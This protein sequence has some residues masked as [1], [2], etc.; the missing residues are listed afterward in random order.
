MTRRPVVWSEAKV[1]YEALL[2]LMIQST[3]PYWRIIV[4]VIDMSL[5]ALV[6]VV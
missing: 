1:I 4:E 5:A 3:D 6:E 2:I